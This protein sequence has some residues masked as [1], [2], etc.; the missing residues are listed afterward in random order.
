MRLS[1][2]LGHMHLLSEYLGLS[3]TSTSKAASCCCAP[4]E[5]KEDQELKSGWVPVTHP[6]G[7]DFLALG[8]TL[9]Q[10]WFF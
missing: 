10:P 1:Y 6:H 7:V 9:A 2:L 3:S 4:W 5:V 8:F